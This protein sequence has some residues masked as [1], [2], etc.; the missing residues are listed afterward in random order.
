MG[1][2][3]ISRLEFIVSSNSSVSQNEGVPLSS[4]NPNCWELLAVG[5]PQSN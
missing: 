5:P 3:S 4:L 1:E 2:Y